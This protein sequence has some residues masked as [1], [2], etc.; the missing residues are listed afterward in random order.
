M[1]LKLTVDSLPAR[2][3]DN[4]SSPGEARSIPS[5]VFCGCSD[6]SVR[7][8]SYPEPTQSR[9]EGVDLTR[10]WVDVTLREGSGFDRRV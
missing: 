6:T 4:G 10:G 5:A 1:I 7:A 9:T 3:N 2:D 8:N